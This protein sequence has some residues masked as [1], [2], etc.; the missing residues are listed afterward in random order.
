MY[1]ITGA[2][3]FIGRNLAK[4]IQQRGMAVRVLSMPGEPAGNMNNDGSA[5]FFIGDLLRPETL[6][7]AVEGI[8]TVIHLAGATHAFDKN[9]YYQVNVQGTKNLLTAC[10]KNNVKKI[11]YISTRAISASGGSYSRSKIEA[12]GLVKNSSMK[13]TILRLA[14]VYGGNKNKGIEHLIGMIRSFPV[15]PIIG[16]GNYRLQ[17]VYIKDVTGAISFVVM[18]SKTDFKTYNIAGPDVLTY[19]DLVKVICRELNLKRLIIHIPGIFAL[20]CAYL[21]YYVFKKIIIYPDQIPRLVSPKEESMEKAMRDIDYKPLKF[22][23]GLKI[24]LNTKYD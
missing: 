1:L 7:G 23:D 12:E 20:A 5:E 11:I 24:I 16:N 4:E 13:F 2:T 8:N 19:N 9:V 21:S 18:N 17:P 22:M 15:I 3:G 6:M 14:E 10:K